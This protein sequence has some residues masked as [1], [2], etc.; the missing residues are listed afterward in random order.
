MLLKSST[1]EVRLQNEMAMFKSV[2]H[3]NCSQKWRDYREVKLVICYPV[4]GH[5]EQDQSD[6]CQ[7]LITANETD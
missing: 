1:W 3:T 6:Q 4:K 2:G 7:G 5:F